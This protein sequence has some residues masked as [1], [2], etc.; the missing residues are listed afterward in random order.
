MRP[1][2][3]FEIGPEV[4]GEFRAARRVPAR[5][6][7]A[8][9]RDSKTKSNRNAGCRNQ[10]RAGAASKR[11]SGGNAEET[12]RNGD[13]SR[14]RPKARRGMNEGR[15]GVEEARK[16]KKADDG[17]FIRHQPFLIV[18]LRFLSGAGPT[19]TDVRLRSN[20]W[21]FRVLQDLSYTRSYGCANHRFREFTLH[22]S[23]FTP[24]FYPL[25]G[26]KIIHSRSPFCLRPSTEPIVTGCPG[27][28]VI[29]YFYVYPQ[30]FPHRRPRT[31]NHPYG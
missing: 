17:P 29:T 7:S 2:A 14:R 22:F 13:G 18:Q 25:L 27:G 21:S 23:S 19:T 20:A 30:D 1:D 8:D 28:T 5:P 11:E 15:D 4:A 16:K 10:P 12:G 26:K 3:G 6:P 31:R 24:Y 9:R